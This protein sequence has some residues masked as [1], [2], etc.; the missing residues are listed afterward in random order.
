MLH[1]R[2]KFY[3]HHYARL[4]QINEPT[5]RNILREKASCSSAAD[6]SF[7]QAGFEQA[8]AALETVLFTR[9]RAG[10]I[11]NPLGSDKWIHSEFYWRR[12]LPRS[13]VINTRQA[14]QIEKLWAGLCPYL[15]HD[16]RNMDYLGGIIR[17]ATGKRDAGYAALTFNEAALLIDALKDRLAHAIKQPA[18]EAPA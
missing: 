7:G 17:K 14:W 15:P 9:V 6:R 10:E 16:K 4:A 12:R 3:L 8:M 2:Q 18:T 11:A 5:Y 13:G 1:N